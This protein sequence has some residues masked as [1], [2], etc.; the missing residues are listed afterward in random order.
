MTTEVE[1]EDAF[2]DQALYQ[3]LSAHDV[4]NDPAW[5]ARVRRFYELRA[6][7]CAEHAE[8][9]GVNGEASVR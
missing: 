2:R 1:V 7:Y 5:I 6:A 9:C 4:R 3:A 8:E